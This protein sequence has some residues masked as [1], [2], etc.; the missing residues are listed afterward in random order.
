MKL[1]SNIS[2]KLIIPILVVLFALSSCTKGDEPVPSSNVGNDDMDAVVIVKD[3]SSL[4][5]QTAR[6]SKGVVGGDDNEDDDDN[7][8]V[9]VIIH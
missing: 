5:A 3:D 8:D 4:N 9:R 2:F 7:K 6:T 1:L